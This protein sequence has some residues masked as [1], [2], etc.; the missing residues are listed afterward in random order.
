LPFYL[1]AAR[2]KN[3][4]FADA[5]EQFRA[6]LRREPAH[7]EA[8]V[9]LADALH[10]SGHSGEAAVQWQRVA[11][12]QSVQAGS[13]QRAATLDWT[14]GRRQLAVT[15]LEQALGLDPA[16]ADVVLLLARVRVLQGQVDV[17]AEVLEQFLTA[18]P[19]RAP[20]LGYLSQLRGSQGRTDD[21][22]Q[23]AERY[24]ALTGNPWEEI[25]D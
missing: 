13:L 9:Q 23:L 5:A 2:A 10:R 6:F 25:R 7:V 20:A 15:K 21:A 8:R 3:G 17:A 18:Y 12:V 19:D 24:R 11:Q 16:N 14:E 22:R 4:Q 1:G